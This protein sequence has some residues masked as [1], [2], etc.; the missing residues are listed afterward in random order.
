LDE[1]NKLGTESGIPKKKVELVK[2]GQLWSQWTSQEKLKM[3]QILN[4]LN[5]EIKYSK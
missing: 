5:K 2:S 3:L 4:N 1:I